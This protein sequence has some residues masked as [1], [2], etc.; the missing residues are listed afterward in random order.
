MRCRCGN[1]APVRSLTCVC[2]CVSESAC[3]CINRWRNAGFRQNHNNIEQSITS[4][5]HFYANTQSQWR[6]LFKGSADRC[7]ACINL[8]SIIRNSWVFRVSYFSLSAYAICGCY[9]IVR[10]GCPTEPPMASDS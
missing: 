5:V 4:P 2:V 6:A 9:S 7:P 1:V 10:C 3:I 8:F